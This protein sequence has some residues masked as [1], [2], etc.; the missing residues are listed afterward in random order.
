M[1]I[2]WRLN[3]HP[4]IDDALLF[5]AC[6]CLTG[7]T[8]LLYKAIPYIYFVQ[9]LTPDNISGA[10]LADTVAKIKW[11]QKADQAFLFI[12]W[13]TIFLVKFSYLFFFRHLIDRLGKIIIYWKVVIVI[14]IMIFCFCIIDGFVACPKT[15]LSAGEL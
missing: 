10:S 5:L 2:R 14:N 12:T 1:L 3:P 9:G 15:G 4:Q 11:F 13:T 8:I 6:I 7:E